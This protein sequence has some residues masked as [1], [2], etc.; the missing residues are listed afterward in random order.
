MSPTADT[1]PIES[2]ESSNITLKT[3]EQQVSDQDK[4]D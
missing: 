1:T 4:K 2:D 3:S